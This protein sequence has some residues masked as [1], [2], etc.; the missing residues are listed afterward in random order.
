M[1]LP[2]AAPV[3]FANMPASVPMAPQPAP[4]IAQPV[5]ARQNAR[6]GAKIKAAVFVAVFAVVLLSPLGQR[7]VRYVCGD[8]LPEGAADL[9]FFIKSTLA[10]WLAVTVAAVIFMREV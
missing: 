2:I 3:Y 5:A 6:F 10:S 7:V 4:A 1:T 9:P 8:T